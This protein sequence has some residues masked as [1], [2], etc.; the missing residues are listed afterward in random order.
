MD[1]LHLENGM[2]SSAK[3][4]EGIFVNT[5]RVRYYRHIKSR[6]H[7]PLHTCVIFEMFD[8]VVNALICFFQWQ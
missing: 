8:R 2:I 6:E 7:K 1:L 4:K 5:S 3:Q